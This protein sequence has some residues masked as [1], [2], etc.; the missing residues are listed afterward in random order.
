MI[1]ICASLGYKSPFLCP[2]GQEKDANLAKANLAKGSKSDLI[3]LVNAYKGWKRGGVS[4]ARQNFL[5]NETMDYIHRLRE[6]LIAATKDVLHNVPEDH[7]DPDLLADA[8]RA[9]LTAG[10]YPNLARLRNRG[11]GNTL[12]GLPVVVHPG[13]VNSKE[14]WSQVAFYEVQETTE[15]YMYDTTVV[16][17]SPVLLFAPVLKEVHRKRSVVFELERAHVKVDVKVADALQSLR[18][19]V[20]T[21]VDRSVGAAPN[22]SMLDMASTLTQLVAEKVITVAGDEGDEEDGGSAVG[23]AS[24]GT[25]NL[26]QSLRNGD[27]GNVEARILADI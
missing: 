15:R 2:M 5:S 11:K 9:V 14:A 16:G 20:S 1:T 17:L 18:G 12:Q 10:L 19:L 4:F 6:D 7:A 3:A 25:Q 22:A 8:C 24:E 21:F 27:L 13:S 26:L 23:D